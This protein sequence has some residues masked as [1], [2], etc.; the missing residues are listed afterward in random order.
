MIN[1]INF[2]QQRKKIRKTSIKCCRE[3]HIMKTTVAFIWVIR[4][5]LNDTWNFHERIISTQ[6]LI[7]SWKCM[8]RKVTKVRSLWSWNQRFLITKNMTWINWTARKKLFIKQSRK[9]IDLVKLY[10]H[11]LLRQKMLSKKK[12]IILK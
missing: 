1:K 3:Q 10:E 6:Q 11:S 2:L 7:I 9:K 4:K 5:I 12:K 8:M